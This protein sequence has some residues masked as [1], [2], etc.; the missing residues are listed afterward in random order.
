MMSNTILYPFR[1]RERRI[2]AA[3]SLSLSR[4]S[5]CVIESQRSRSVSAGAYIVHKYRRR[6]KQKRQLERET[7]TRVQH[8]R[9]SMTGMALDN[10]NDRWDLAVFLFL[11]LHSLLFLYFFVI[12]FGSHV[13]SGFHLSSTRRGEDGECLDARL[14][15][16]KPQTQ[17]A[18]TLIDE[19]GEREEEEE[20]AKRER[21]Q[22][23]VMAYHLSCRI[24][25]W[26]FVICSLF[27][28]SLSLSSAALPKGLWCR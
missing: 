26:L 17:A 9:E 15:T 22:D 20:E 5:L 1:S 13:F 2:W 11:F 24:L 21:V 6:A 14:Y 28:F 23:E 18:D 19:T 4:L 7:W 27:F 25:L 8:K 12:F 3:S 10:G 16:K